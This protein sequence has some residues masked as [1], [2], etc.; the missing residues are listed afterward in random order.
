MTQGIF[1]ESER[2]AQSY[3]RRVRGPDMTLLS[4]KSVVVREVDPT[5]LTFSEGLRLLQPV[6]AFR[7]TWGVIGSAGSPGV[8]DA[9]SPLVLA[10]KCLSLRVVAFPSPQPSTLA[11]SLSGLPSSRFVYLGEL[12]TDARARDT[13]AEESEAASRRNRETVIYSIP[14]GGA[15]AT[16]AVT[17]LLA[18]LHPATLLAVAS[19]LCS[20]GQSVLT[21]PVAVWRARGGAG[22][23]PPGGPCVVLWY[24]GADCAADAQLY[25]SDHS[26]TVAPKRYRGGAPAGEVG[27]GGV[28]RRQAPFSK[29]AEPM[30][31]TP[32]VPRDEGGG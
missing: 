30:T 21:F 10:A 26:A 29:W 13:A 15:A 16:A 7:E 22:E 4:E 31:Y 27:G 12:P 23:I 9:W 2:T 32:D 24:A 3:W 20:P 18:A 17:G 11:L 6:R 5:T 19:A 25:W 28:G 14:A 8:G 1:A